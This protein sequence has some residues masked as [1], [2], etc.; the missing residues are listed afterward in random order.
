MSKFQSRSL[1]RSETRQKYLYELEGLLR[2]AFPE[3]SLEA[4]EQLLF[5]Q[6]IRGLPR[7]IYENIRLSPDITTSEGAM[8][9]AQVLVRLQNESSGRVEEEINSVKSPEEIHVKENLADKV[10]RR[11]VNE[12]VKQITERFSILACNESENTICAVEGRRNKWRN[13]LRGKADGYERTGPRGY[14]REKRE[15]TIICYMCRGEGHIARECANNRTEKQFRCY[16]CKRIG[17]MAG[18][19]PKPPTGNP[20]N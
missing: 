1:H 8:K 14:E 16:N 5:E 19:C 20:L 3:M 9:R 10:D 2:K 11:L 15:R 6:Y 17:H 13:E 4:K 12:A 18:S 7:L